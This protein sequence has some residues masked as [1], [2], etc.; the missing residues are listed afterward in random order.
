MICQNGGK[1]FRDDTINMGF[2]TF[3]VECPALEAALAKSNAASEAIT[4]L[5]IEI[6]TPPPRQVE[7][8]YHAPVMV[9]TPNA[10]AAKADLKAFLLSKHR[11]NGLMARL[12]KVWNGHK[13]DVVPLP[14]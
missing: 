8:I 13:V 5:G 2:L 4:L 1:Q 14:K 11:P 3:E 10:E 9:D 6:F 7:R 12:K